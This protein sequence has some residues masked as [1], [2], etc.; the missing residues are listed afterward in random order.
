[1]PRQSSIVKPYHGELLGGRSCRSIIRITGCDF[2]GLQV[3]KQPRLWL[4]LQ[5]N[6]PAGSGL[7]FDAHSSYADEFGAKEMPAPTA[8]FQPRTKPLSTAKFDGTS[9]YA[10]NYIAY[11]L[12]ADGKR[13][14]YRQQG[15]YQHCNIPFTATSAYEVR[16]C[17][18]H[19]GHSKALFIKR[20]WCRLKRQGT[21]SNSR[22]SSIN[23]AARK[24]NGCLC[25]S[26]P[27][28]CSQRA[29]FLGTQ[30]ILQNPPP[31]NDSPH[32]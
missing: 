7:K 21:F 28:H 15:P 30:T 14:A 19:P 8:P 18:M 20:L 22:T 23:F 1:M 3:W 10:D 26:S 27:C 17:V 31:L 13:P 24:V 12:S 25:H 5:F 32:L 9:S 29:Y 4:C 16:L 6:R 11:D 2:W